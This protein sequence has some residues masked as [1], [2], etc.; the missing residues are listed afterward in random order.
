M[1]KSAK[2]TASNSTSWADHAPTRRGA[3]APCRQ[4]RRR[5]RSPLVRRQRRIDGA[6]DEQLRR[7][8]RRARAP[9]VMP[10]AP[11]VDAGAA[12]V[13]VV[14]AWSRFLRIRTVR[15]PRRN[16]G[17]ETR[18]RA[19]Q[20]QSAAGRLAARQAKHIQFID[21]RG[22]REVPRRTAHRIDFVRFGAFPR[23]CPRAKPR[24]K[25]RMRRR[26]PA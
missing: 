12:M 5:R 17:G 18:R 11:C 3:E 6:R 4:R 8:T 23:I 21:H 2:A 24:R 20:G 7:T 14:I 19:P 1:A 9:L 10:P 22:T 25:M 15:T 13:S 16:A 26:G